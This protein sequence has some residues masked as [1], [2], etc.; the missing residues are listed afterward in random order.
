ML[1]AYLWSGLAAS[2]R[3]QHEAL[4]PQQRHLHCVSTAAG[5][6]ASRCEASCD[7]AKLPWCSHSECLCVAPP[8]QSERSARLS[9]VVLLAAASGKATDAQAA[10]EYAASALA[11]LIQKRAESGLKCA[12]L[13][14]EVSVEWCEAN[15]KDFPSFCACDGGDAATSA[16]AETAA[17]P[18]E[19]SPTPAE[20]EVAPAEAATPATPVQAPAPEAPAPVAVQQPAPA[21]TTPVPAVPATAEPTAATA[22][23][24]ATPVNPAADASAP[25][26]EVTTGEATAEAVP[27]GKTFCGSK[28]MDDYFN[29]KCG[30]SVASIAAEC[31]DEHADDA[32]CDSFR[33]ACIK[34]H[35][36]SGECVDQEDCEDGCQFYDGI[37]A[38]CCPHVRQALNVSQLKGPNHGPKWQARYGDGAESSKGVKPPRTAEERVKRTSGVPPEGPDPAALDRALEAGAERQADELPGGDCEVDPNTDQGVDVA[39]CNKN[40][41]ADPSKSWC[42]MVCMCPERPQP[43]DKV[44]AADGA[45]EA[46]KAQPGPTPTPNDYCGSPAHAQHF[47]ELCTGKLLSIMEDCC[48]QACI[49]HLKCPEACTEHMA[50]CGQVQV[51]K[52][53]C[54]DPYDCDMGNSVFNQVVDSCCIR[55]PPPVPPP[56]APPPHRVCYT[57]KQR[58]RG[59]RLEESQALADAPEF[60]R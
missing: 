25:N 4:A 6:T 45:P 1:V 50:A 34:G 21:A 42:T 29:N 31:C 15:Y 39:W 35:V 38:T 32:K 51:D 12:V 7:A 23:A 46:P 16:S 9:N 13:K 59:E 56:S 28:E 14:D 41:K 53:I 20:P 47:D 22:P 44:A 36:L 49:Y 48:T 19:A 27:G 58:A 37:T 26:S 11:A 8:D 17:A 40:C 54:T 43:K 3:V 2:P 60:L 30:N 52:G 55:A 18:A 24:A 33:L 10:R 57:H 5:T